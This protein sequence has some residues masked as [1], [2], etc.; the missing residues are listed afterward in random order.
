MDGTIAKRAR[1][2]SPF[3]I[4][5]LTRL[6][7]SAA[8]QMSTDQIVVLIGALHSEVRRRRESASAQWRTLGPKLKARRAG[9]G[10]VG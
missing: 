9:I 8:R 3:E 2:L 1:G 4:E 5:A 7:L 10:F 6:V